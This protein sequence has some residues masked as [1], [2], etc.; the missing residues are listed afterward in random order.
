MIKMTETIGM[1]ESSYLSY[2][3]RLSQN[4]YQEYQVLSRLVVLDSSLARP[5][6]YSLDVTIT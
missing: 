1:T 3:S 4:D 5:I 6:L 2:L